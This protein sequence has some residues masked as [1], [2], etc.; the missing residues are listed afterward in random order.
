M[1]AYPNKKHSFR[2]SILNRGKKNQKCEKIFYNISALKV[3]S[4]IPYRRSN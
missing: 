1:I 2:D 3:K 4:V